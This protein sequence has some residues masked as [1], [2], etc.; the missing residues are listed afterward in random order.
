M[1]VIGVQLRFARPEDLSI[2]SVHTQQDP[3]AP[4]L[5]G[6]G[7]ED[8]VAPQYRRRMPAGR[9]RQAPVKVFVGEGRGDVLRFTNASPIRPA[10]AR[11][12]LG[13]RGLRKCQQL[14]FRFTA[15]FLSN[16]PELGDVSRGQ[17][18][19]INNYY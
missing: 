12:L 17:V 14:R 9:K 19:S 8:L 16:R 5:G 15:I 1:L 18:V 13:M 10:E 6:A 3:L 11:P 2:D 7:D 4:I